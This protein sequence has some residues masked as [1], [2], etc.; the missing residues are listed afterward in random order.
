MLEYEVYERSN[1]VD[2]CVR[3]Y[4]MDPDENRMTINEEEALSEIQE[5]EEP[6]QLDKS[7][8]SS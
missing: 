3:V 7:S 4:F 6:E 5:E 8:A 2:D 1:G